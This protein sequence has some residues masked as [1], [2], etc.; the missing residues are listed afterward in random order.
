M[1]RPDEMASV[2]KGPQGPHLHSGPFRQ[3]LDNLTQVSSSGSLG[4]VSLKPQHLKNFSASLLTSGDAW[5]QPLTASC[6]CWSSD[7][8]KHARAMLN[9]TMK[10]IKRMTIKKNR[11]TWLC[12]LVPIRPRIATKNKNP[13][14]VMIPPKIWMLVTI[15][16]AFPYAATPT[17]M[18]ETTCY[19]LAYG[20]IRCEDWFDM[21]ERRCKNSR[22]KEHWVM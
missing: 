10:S 21:D 5:F 3:H 4:A 1:V 15:D 22:Y 8:A 13:P 14:H 17:K 6:C 19:S 11:R 18:N 16:A 9:C 12:F 2:I 20:K 7:T